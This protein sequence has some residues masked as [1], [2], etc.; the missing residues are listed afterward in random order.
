MRP[1]ASPG[2]AV[3]ERASAVAAPTKRTLRC[4]GVLGSPDRSPLTDA[5]SGHPP[6]AFVT[7]SL[8]RPSS[9]IA[10]EQVFAAS[11]WG[12]A[13]AWTRAARRSKRALE[14]T[15]SSRPTSTPSKTRRACPVAASF[16]SIFSADARTSFVATH[17]QLSFRGNTKTSSGTPA[18]AANGRGTARHETS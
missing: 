17:V 5:P 13:V 9:S 16:T 1:S 14:F 11:R 3:S 12:P 8:T 10:P 6:L 7:R 18:A 15:A 2:V 4:A